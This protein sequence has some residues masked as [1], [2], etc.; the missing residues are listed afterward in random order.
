[1]CCAMPGRFQKCAFCPFVAAS[2]QV[3]RLPLWLVEGR[4]GETKLLKRMLD[5]DDVLGL[6]RKQAIVA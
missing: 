2:C 4:P 5:C 1:M 3:W 6:L